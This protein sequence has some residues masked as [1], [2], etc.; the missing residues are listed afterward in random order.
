MIYIVDIPADNSAPVIK[1]AKKVSDK[2]AVVKGDVDHDIACAEDA[3][4]PAEVIY[5]NRF[6]EDEGDIVEPRRGDKGPVY[7]YTKPF[8]ETVIKSFPTITTTGCYFYITDKYKV[9]SA[10]HATNINIFEYMNTPREAPQ[11]NFEEPLSDV[12]EH[13]ST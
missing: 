8:L 5:E 4:N 6:E 7:K 11:V 2:K 12:D 9:I 10:P 1:K 3:I 13:K